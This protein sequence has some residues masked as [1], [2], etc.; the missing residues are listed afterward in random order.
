MKLNTPIPH[1]FNQRHVWTPADK[2]AWKDSPD[3]HQLWRRKPD[4]LLGTTSGN[5]ESEAGQ[6][7]HS[8]FTETTLPCPIFLPSV[9]TNNALFCPGPRPS[10][11]RPSPP[12]CA[13]HPHEPSLPTH[14]VCPHTFTI[15]FKEGFRYLVV[16]HRGQ[17]WSSMAP[18]LCPRD[19][20][21][22]SLQPQQQPQPLQAL[23]ESTPSKFLPTGT[24]LGRSLCEWA[25]A[26][27]RG[28]AAQTFRQRV[29]RSR[30]WDS[31][32]ASVGGRYTLDFGGGLLQR[33]AVHK[34]STLGS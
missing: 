2:T 29:F 11:S 31:V 17:P 24:W 26:G 21:W 27:G 9:E 20:L 12:P 1:A 13:S 33:E 30:R 25:P 5:Q 18:S 3:F 8:P 32:L 10:M 6:S 22:G 7:G 14:R 28:A 15:S 19:S 16:L 23:S 34:A 4:K